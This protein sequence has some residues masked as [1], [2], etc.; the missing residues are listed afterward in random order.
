MKNLLLFITCALLLAA[1]ALAQKDDKKP[2]QWP[3][4][5]RLNLMVTD[6]ANKPVQDLKT[7]DIK[8]YENNVE[9]K[10]TYLA[11]KPVSN[12][13]FVMD[14]TGSMRQQLE[15]VIKSGAAI[16]ANLDD[17]VETM[18][19]RFVGS[20]NVTIVQPWTANKGPVRRAMFNMFIQGGQ[21]VVRDAVY[22]AAQKSLEESKT[23]PDNRSAIILISDGED[24][25][26]TYKD[27]DIFSLIGGTDIQIYALGLVGDLDSEAGFIRKS[28]KN[29]S[30]AFI[31]TLT[32]RSG[33]SAYIIGPK[34]TDEDLQAAVTSLSAE[35]RSPFVMGYTSTD[36]DHDGKER[37]LRVEIAD[38]PNGEKRTGV[39]RNSFTVPKY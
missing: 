25:A 5:V 17:T 26:S 21:S 33:G 35:L 31:H 29:K 36:Q 15:A 22:L 9:Q 13:V 7:S 8:L 20:D 16:A 39:V 3:V 4:E 32:D 10:I 27:A 23:L 34:S 6:A 28:P 38:G 37:K 30:V 12:V 19:I 2:E 18:V 14:N 11:K 24:R 1:T